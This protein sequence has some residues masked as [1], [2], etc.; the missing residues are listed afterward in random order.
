MMSAF[1]GMIN[2]TIQAY[3]QPPQKGE[4][5]LIRKCSECGSIMEGSCYRCCY[6]RILE[7]EARDA[8]QKAERAIDAAWER[9]R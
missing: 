9:C 6:A 5:L 2:G 1:V 7:S 3:M 8:N 4:S